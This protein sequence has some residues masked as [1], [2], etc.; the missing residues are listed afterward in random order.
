MFSAM[1]RSICIVGVGARTA[2]GTT[3]PATAA[4]MRA[5][6]TAMGNHPFMIDKA[7]NPMVVCVDPTLP[8]QLDTLE[9]FLELALRPAYEALMP[10]LENSKVK[11]RISILIALPEDRPGTPEN[12][13]N[14]FYKRFASEIASHIS[15]QELHCYPLGLKKIILKKGN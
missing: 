14:E 2:V 1:D 4:A 15:I 11:P 7:G 13:R 9:R 5:G 12:F 3:A 8:V 6:I 10:V